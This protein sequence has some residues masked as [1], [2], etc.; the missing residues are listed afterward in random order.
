[1][2]KKLE[3]FANSFKLSVCT[4]PTAVIMFVVIIILSTLLMSIPT[5]IFLS[6]MDKVLASNNITLKRINKNEQFDYTNYKSIGNA[7][8][9][10]YHNDLFQTDANLS[11]LLQGYKINIIKESGKPITDSVRLILVINGN[12]FTREEI[13]DGVQKILVSEQA[14][15]H[16]MFK[17][18][19]EVI[20]CG[21]K[22]VVNK[23]KK[24]NRYDSSLYLPYTAELKNF[25]YLNLDK[26]SVNDDDR[27]SFRNGHL[28]LQ[29]SVRNLNSNEKSILKSFGFKQ[30][31]RLNEIYYEIVPFLLFLIPSLILIV[32]NTLFVHMYIQK[33]NSRKYAIYKILGTSPNMQSGIMFA[34][35]TALTLFGIGLGILIEFIIQ[36][37]KISDAMVLIKLNWLNY[38]L[39]FL[40]IMAISLITT[41]IK[42]VSHVK[43]KPIEEKF[44]A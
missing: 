33:I 19:E 8:N 22:F 28:I 42:I 6:S 14:M 16:Y 24:I 5:K 12:G 29:D 7:I 37:F 4:K 30:D 15:T 38:L 23:S 18:N 40:F 13:N 11:I 43:A 34:E 25:V 41:G 3:L 20:F 31:L 9:G 39:I 2:R 35:I 10:F 21:S 44:L 17:E 32:V 36:L 26:D 1:M 27:P